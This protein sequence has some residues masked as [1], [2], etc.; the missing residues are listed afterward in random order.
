MLRH[1]IT[2]GV[3]ANSSLLKRKKT[4]IKIKLDE[5]KNP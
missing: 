2:I 1:D 4:K 3:E 5:K